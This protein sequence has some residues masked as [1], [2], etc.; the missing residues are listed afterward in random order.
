MAY[1]RRNRRFGLT[2]AQVQAPG[3]V[4][5]P[6]LPTLRGSSSTDL[7]ATVTATSSSSPTSSSSS[8]SEGSDPEPRTAAQ[9]R[10]R[11]TAASR[12]S[13]SEPLRSRRSRSV[14]QLPGSSSGGQASVAPHSKVSAKAPLSRLLSVV[15]L[16]GGLTRL[17]GPPLANK[18]EPVE[19]TR[20][21][22][23]R[24]VRHEI[25]RLV[26]AASVHY[27]ALVLAVP[28]VLAER[29]AWLPVVGW[30]SQVGLLSGGAESALTVFVPSSCHALAA[31]TL[32]RALPARSP[33][34]SVTTSK[35]SIDDD[36]PGCSTD[37]PR[38]G[39]A[40]GDSVVVEWMTPSWH[41][42]SRWPWS[43]A[44][45]WDYESA[46]G[47]CTGRRA[48]AIPSLV[49]WSRVRRFCRWLAVRRSPGVGD[50][51]SLV[52][53]RV[54]ALLDGAMARLKSE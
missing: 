52:A 47:C 16:P 23:G 31:D 11:L 29:Q 4:V 30:H 1:A 38:S 42:L 28:V 40:Y 44:A 7:S 46:I 49:S 12:S 41:A 2:Q 51:A 15:T 14:T 6:A 20:A 26:G 45:E 27:S 25:A 3:T 53:S 37:E 54:H 22:R 13:T 48:S 5:P 17:V 8:D 18:D 39:V 21:L 19:L 33:H 9:P 50:P 10:V 24:E 43:E 34:D 35:R 32:A 36:D